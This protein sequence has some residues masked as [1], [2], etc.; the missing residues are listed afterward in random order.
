MDS[1]RSISK[2]LTLEFV[3]RVKVLTLLRLLER[4]VYFN[5]RA[6]EQCGKRRTGMADKLP[7]WFRK[8]V[9]AKRK[10]HCVGQILLV[11]VI[12]VQLLLY[13]KGHAS[14]DR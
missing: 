1:E 10:A 5:C 12:T 9:G 3:G 2:F 11:T 8:L 6:V 4:L 14:S 7:I 13:P